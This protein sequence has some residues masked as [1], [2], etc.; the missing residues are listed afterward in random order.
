[1]LSFT[2]LGQVA[3]SKE[4][5]PLHQFRSQKEAALLIYLAHTRQ[6]HQREFIAELLWDASTTRQGLSNLRTLLTRLRKQ[7]GDAL[8]VT[9]KTVALTPADYQQ[10]DSV[11][12]LKTLSHSGPINSAERANAL[13]KALDTYQGHFLADFNLPNA[14]QFDEWIIATREHI[15]HEVVSAYQKLEQYA[16]DTND[17]TSAMVI[18]RRWLAVDALD[19]TAHTLLIQQLI[20][21]GKVREAVAHYDSSTTLLQTELGIEPPDQMSALIEEARPQLAMPVRQSPTM[22]HNLPSTYDQFFGRRAVQEEIHVRLDQ[23]WCRL[24]TLTGQG[25]VGKTR[26]ATTIARSR[27]TQ[28]RDGVWWIELADL[29]PDDDDLVETI[30]VEM[31][32][33]LD[34]RLTGKATPVEQLLTHLKHKQLFLVLDNFEHVL[35]GLPLVLEVVQKCEQVQLL[36][37]SREALRVRAEWTVALVGLSYPAGDTDT[38]PSDAVELFTARRAQQQWQALSPT[39]LT[40]IRTICHMVE[41]LPLAIELAAALTRHATIP[42]VAKRLQDNFDALTVPLYNLPERH[43]GLYNVFDMSW[44]TLTPGLQRRLARLAVFQ[45]GFSETAAHQITGANRQHL[46][47][48]ADKS[49][50]TYQAESDRHTLHPIIRAY[51]AKKRPPADATPQKHAHYYLTLLA[52][53]TEPLQKD[54]PQDSMQQLEP[55]SDNLR[56][57]WQTGLAE[58]QADKLLDALTSL[59][60]YYQLRGLSREGEAVMQTTVKM[61]QALGSAGL[62]LAIRAGLEQARFQNRL[63]QHRPAMQTLKTVLERAAQSTDRWAEGM[64][65][66]WWGE[67]LWRLGEYDTAKDKLAHALTLAHTFDATLIVG[68]CHHQLGIIHDIQSRYDIAKYHLEKACVA[69]RMIDNANTLSVSLNSIGI[70][71]YH[72]GD[73]IAARDAMEQSLAICERIDNCHLQALLLNNLNNIH[74]AQGDYMG[75]QYYLQLGFELAIASGNL[76]GQGEIATNLGR[77]HYRLGENVL[78]V[79]KMEQG[80]QIAETIGDYSVM[81]TALVNLAE[82]KEVLNE[83]KQAETLYNQALGVARQIGQKRTEFTA[84]IGLAEL[85]GENDVIQA[86]QFSTEA[87]TLA[88]VL[89]NQNFLERTKAVE[90]NLSILA[91]IKNKEPVKVTGSS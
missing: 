63:G 3:L 45:A 78:A 89:Q 57:A 17:L 74:D 24:V 2:L 73:L 77:I 21:T 8:L 23:P 36:I 66:V 9:R 46:A 43:R 86:R 40:A 4:G 42:T 44:R 68:W 49:L 75:A 33:A 12:L 37:T 13:Q 29:D 52:Q 83:S 16:R 58:R 61:A 67:A 62:A 91:D 88:A 34:L 32:I 84:L 90:Q 39:D 22:R 1:M 18:T 47:A 7:V 14:P 6:T 87:T 79:E 56:L 64:A 54:R 72:Q 11:N 10:V 35:A 69:W 51:A 50:L 31:A 70:V 59:S 71:Y 30:A 15:R 25:G 53:H 80:L 65:H 28:Y 26:L 5:K 27:L 41:G 81:A 85:L 82:V 20:E 55:D 60:V 48:L 76:T 19:E 38:T